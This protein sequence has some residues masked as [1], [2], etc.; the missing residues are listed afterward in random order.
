MQPMAANGSFPDHLR[1][2]HAQKDTVWRRSQLRVT[3]L[4]REDTI[5]SVHYGKDGRG[6]GS[7]GVS[8]TVTVSCTRGEMGDEKLRKLKTPVISC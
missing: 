7:C 4:W 5:G 3:C 6:D 2:G 1:A 8:S